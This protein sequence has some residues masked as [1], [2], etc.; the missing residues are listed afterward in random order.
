M[1]DD[2]ATATEPTRE[3]L[4]AALKDKHGID[5]PALQAQ[6]ESTETAASLSKT[7]L[8][9]L[10]EAGVVK[11][12]NT[13]AATVSNEDV[14]SAVAELAQNNVAL[15]NKVNGLERLAAQTAV[16]ALIAEG[17]VLPKQRKAMVELKL[18]APGMFDELV[19]AEPVVK[20]NHEKGADEPDDSQH[21][22][23]IDEEVARLSNMLNKSASK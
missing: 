21:N 15:T 5:V 1:P 4:L 10:T 17:K 6:A 20:L 9:A 3:E 2:V 11:L 18:S 19:P 8:D 12:A 16:D 23:N 22:L 13:D 7:L 14:V